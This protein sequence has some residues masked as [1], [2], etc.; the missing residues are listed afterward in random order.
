MLCAVCRRIGLDADGANGLMRED[1]N[2]HLKDSYS[3]LKQSA[4]TG[5]DC[6]ALVM[7]SLEH[8][9]EDNTKRGGPITLRRD[10]YFKFVRS[11]Y[12]DDIGVHIG[13]EEREP[14]LRIFT[15]DGMVYLSFRMKLLTERR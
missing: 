5:C 10:K 11:P 12:I 14:R 15:T 2:F 13:G 7:E 8:W 9:K 4:E 1:F 3:S 6:C